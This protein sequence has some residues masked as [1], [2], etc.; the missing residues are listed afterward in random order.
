V[1][2]PSNLPLRLSSFV[3]REKELAE[4]RRLLGDT[5]LLTLTGPGGC[6]KTRL[7]VV[8]ASEQLQGFEDGVQM[9]ELA[10]LS[11][12]SFVPQAVAS[13][14]GA[15]EQSDFSLTETLSNHLRGKNMLLVL[16]NCEH[17]IEA[18]AELVETLLRTCPQLR[19]L[20][21]SRE[22]LAMPG[23]VAWPVP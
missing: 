20:A 2:P 14:L 10:P 18:C 5:R 8:A 22:A 11:D 23:E 7:A 15:R 9:V 13:V 16:D 4:V 17:L 1:S 21:T 19:V 12:P 3:G 6:G